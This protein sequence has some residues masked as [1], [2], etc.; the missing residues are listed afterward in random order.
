MIGTFAAKEVFVAQL[1][2][3]HALGDSG[4]DTASLR[5]ALRHEYS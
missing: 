2:I 4:H 1:G 3:T 5:G